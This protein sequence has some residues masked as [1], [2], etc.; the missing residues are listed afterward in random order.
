[1]TDT[2]ATPGYNI[3][4]SKHHIPEYA[5]M[6]LH[7]VLLLKSIKRN[8]PQ[9]RINRFKQYQNA[10]VY[11]TFLSLPRS[12]SLSCS[13][14]VFQGVVM[15][16]KS[17]WTCVCVCL[18]WFSLFASGLGMKGPGGLVREA[19]ADVSWP[20]GTRF[21][22]IRLPSQAGFGSILTSSRSVFPS[23][24]PIPLLSLTTPVSLCV[25]ACLDVHLCTDNSLEPIHPSFLNYLTNYYWCNTQ[26]ILN[27]YT[28]SH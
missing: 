13:F 16:T 15:N 21:S 12:C 9:K 27:S 24:H 28:L 23:L 6:L 7:F 20:V 10:V 2:A 1:M 11:V 3:F 25:S 4:P 14:C 22:R 19:L 5:S 8:Q 17:V 26:P 18:L